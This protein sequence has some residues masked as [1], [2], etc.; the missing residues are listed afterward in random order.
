MSIPTVTDLSAPRPRLREHD[1]SKSCKRVT[2]S[3]YRPVRLSNED[4]DRLAFIQRFYQT[5]E[6][7]AVSGAEAVRSA[8]N[9]HAAQLRAKTHRHSSPLAS[10]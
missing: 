1:P 6:K 8:I 5:T 7:R 10:K 9:A 3:N 2:R 4:M